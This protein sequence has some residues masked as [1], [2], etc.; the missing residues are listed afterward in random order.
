MKGPL[1]NLKFPFQKIHFVGLVRII[2]FRTCDDTSDH[3]LQDYFL[4]GARAGASF[5][6]SVNK[7]LPK[8]LQ[9]PP[10]IITLRQQDTKGLGW[11]PNT[12]HRQV[13]EGHSRQKLVRELVARAHKRIP[14]S[15]IQSNI[16][17]SI[18]V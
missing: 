6:V 16:Y 14:R 11:L 12:Y 9:N 15:Y 10:R 7:L 4:L 5:K 8:S 3:Q 17:S 13:Q 18:T 2:I 1:G